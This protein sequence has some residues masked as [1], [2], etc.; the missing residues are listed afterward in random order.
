MRRSS[1]SRHVRSL[2]FPLIALATFLCFA[3]V[4]LCWAKATPPIDL[5]F[6]HEGVGSSPHTARLALFCTPRVSAEAIRL[7][8]RLPKGTRLIAGALSWEGSLE[9]RKT[10]VCRFTVAFPPGSYGRVTA[11]ATTARYGVLRSRGGRERRRRVRVRARSK[12]PRW[13]QTAE[14]AFNRKARKPAPGRLRGRTKAVGGRR[15]KAGLMRP[16]GYREI[17]GASSERHGE[18]GKR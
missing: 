15:Q 7:A 4:P 1:T 13:V 10:R 14:W 17:V 8:I 18:K 3:S 11:T 2:G 12:A 6:V 9:A 16:G 5:S